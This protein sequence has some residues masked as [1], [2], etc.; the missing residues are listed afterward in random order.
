M[1]FAYFGKVVIS[2]KRLAG[3]LK[4][5]TQCIRNHGHN[6]VLR[7]WDVHIWQGDVTIDG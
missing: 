2:M 7:V 5:E 1:W 4:E 6:L 3:K